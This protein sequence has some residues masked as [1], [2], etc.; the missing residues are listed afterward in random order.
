MA[1]K[2]YCLVNL[3]SNICENVVTWDGVI[4]YEP[5]ENFLLLSQLDTPAKNWTF[6]ETTNDWEIEEI[7]YGQIGFTWDGTYLI[8]NAPKPDP[9]E[10]PV[11]GTQDI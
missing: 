11:I 6:N 2:S 7:G 10:V 4:P 9:I 5:P 8:T 1:D 3:Q